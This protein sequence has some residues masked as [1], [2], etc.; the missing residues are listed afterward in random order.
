V[1]RY[2]REPFRGFANPQTC[3]TASGVEVLSPDGSLASIPYN[4]VKMVCF[5]RALE[6]PQLSSERREFLARPKTMGLWIG[7]VFRDGDRLEGTIPN[8]LLLFEPYGFSLTPPEASG[9]TQRVFVPRQSLT[10]IQVLGVVGSPARAGRRAK[11]PSVDQIK[12]FSE[13]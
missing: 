2:D 4:Q 5:V 13:D 11:P 10:E 12:L 3:L 1:E 9:N 6:G 7:L 8:N